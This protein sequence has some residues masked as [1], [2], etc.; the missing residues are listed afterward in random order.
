M[1]KHHRNMRR[2]PAPAPADLEP[3]KWGIRGKVTVWEGFGPRREIK[4]KSGQ[5]VF[6][7]VFPQV[8]VEVRDTRFTAPP[9]TTKE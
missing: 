7:P 5:K 4:I 1:E 2:S 8:G 9:N 3:P 6:A